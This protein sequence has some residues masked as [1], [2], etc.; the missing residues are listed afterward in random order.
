LGS[1]IAGA[2]PGELKALLLVIADRIGPSLERSVLIMRAIDNT[3]L[4]FD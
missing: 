4:T 1:T 2:S 3:Y